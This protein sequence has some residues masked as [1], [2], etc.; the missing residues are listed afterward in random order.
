MAKR[1]NA[2]DYIDIEIINDAELRKLFTELI[3]SV[4]NRIVLSGMRNASKIILQQAKSNFKGRQKNKS[5]TNY[6]NFNK[7][8]TTEP[9]R[10]TFGLKVGVKNYKYKWI[11]WGTDDRYYKR[12]V[13]RSTW[14]KRKDNSG[15]HYT[16]KIIAT[17]FFFDAV[18]SRKEQAKKIVSEAI[19][20]SLE[21]TVAKYNKK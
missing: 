4:Q 14:R 20:Q 12:G 19:V 13:K 21:K 10:S 1:P 16:G 6:S 11:E 9:M 15:G 3:P 7:S 2:E 18:N 17:N 5:L 8:F